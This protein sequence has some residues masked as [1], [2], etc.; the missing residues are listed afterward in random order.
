MLGRQWQ[1]AAAARE[2]GNALIEFGFGELE[3]HRIYAE[4][5]SE[6]KAAIKL[7]QA[8]RM[9]IESERPDDRFFKCRMW[10]TTVLAISQNEWRARK[11]PG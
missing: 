4:T 5:I 11:K 7:C 1:G 9:R 6:N 2:A 10:S 3:L 8:F